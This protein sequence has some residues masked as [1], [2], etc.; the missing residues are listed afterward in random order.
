M[1]MV[2][3][4]TMKTKTK[5]NKNNIMKEEELSLKEQIYSAVVDTRIPSCIMAAIN[6]DS[7]TI[8]IKGTTGTIETYL[9]NDT[10]TIKT[11]WTTSEVINSQLESVVKSYVNNAEDTSDAV[12]D[13]IIAL[14]EVLIK[15]A[16]KAIKDKDYLLTLSYALEIDKFLQYLSW[17]TDSKAYKVMA[18]V[19]V[20]QIPTL[21][22]LCD[23]NYCK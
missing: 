22:Q 11:R 18:K 23:E 6:D 21:K 19:L 4:M 17:V 20:N 12:Q 9:D 14:E 5:I 3:M 7:I 15:G 10:N 2:I 13:C 8:Y 1:S 16:N